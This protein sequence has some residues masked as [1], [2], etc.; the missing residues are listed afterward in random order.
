MIHFK[1]KKKGFSLIEAL[2]AIALVGIVLTPLFILQGASLRSVARLSRHLH[3]IYAAER[4][5]F[6]SQR[7]VALNVRQLVLEKKLEDPQTVLK[8]E[9]RDISKESSLKDVHDIVAE[10]VTMRWEEDGMWRQDQILNFVF[11]PRE[12]GASS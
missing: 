6:E 7:S 4:F 10:Q 5:L 8:Y 12:N 3:R 1:N 2:L 9:L 11:K